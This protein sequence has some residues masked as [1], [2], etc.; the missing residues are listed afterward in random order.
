M[1]YVKPPEESILPE[2]RKKGN[3]KENKIIQCIELNDQQIEEDGPDVFQNNKGK[4]K[5]CFV[6]IFLVNSNFKKLLAI[7]VFILILPISEIMLADN[8]IKFLV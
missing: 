7:K 5:N 3:T 8:N 2:K 1:I 6:K 4:F